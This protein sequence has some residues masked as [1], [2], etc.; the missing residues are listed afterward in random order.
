MLFNDLGKKVASIFL[1]IVSHIGKN[2]RRMRTK[3]GFIADNVV[4]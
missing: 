2:D 1:I 3:H 4:Y